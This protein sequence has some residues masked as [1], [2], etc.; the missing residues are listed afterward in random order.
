MGKKSRKPKIEHIKKKKN[1][2]DRI[3]AVDVAK[4]KLSSIGLSGE[5]EGVAKFYEVC[6]DYINSGENRSG[7]IE[8]TGFKRILEYILPTSYHADVS[9][10]LKYDKTV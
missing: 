1:M 5:I 3:K 6:E 9:V 7:K 8:L 10:L 2:S 4:E